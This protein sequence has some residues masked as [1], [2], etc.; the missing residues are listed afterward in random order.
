MP[1]AETQFSYPTGAIKR[2]PEDGSRS[3][4][5]YIN[6]SA[7]TERLRFTLETLTYHQ[8]VHGHHFQMALDRENTVLPKFRRYGSFTAYVEGWVLFT[9]K[10]GYELGELRILQLRKEAKQRFGGP[11]RPPAIPRRTSLRR[12]HAD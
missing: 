2:P 5:F 4:C 1:Q 9:E 7:P 8:A 12:C 3:G 6:T 10:L 11:V